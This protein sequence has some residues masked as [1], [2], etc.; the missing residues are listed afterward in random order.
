MSAVLELAREL[1]ARP[2]LTPDDA[3]CQQLIGA[4]LAKLSFKIEHLRFGQVDNLWARHGNSSPLLV[5]AGHTDV[6]PPGPKEQWK[7]DPFTP[8][9]RDGFLYGRGTADM[10]TGLAAMTVA[11]EQFITSQP[12]HRGSLAFLITS[13]EEGPS[14]DGTV[15]VMEELKDRG[16]KID[17]CVLGEPSCLEKFGDT[18]RHGRRGSLTGLLHVYGIQG[19]VAYPERADNPIH[20]VVPAL[21]ELCATKW[22]TSA[23]LHFPPTSFQISNFNSGTGAGNVIPGHADVRFNFRYSTA[24]T[25]VE[26]QQRVHEILD[27]H[28]LRYELEWRPMGEPFLTKPGE[29]SGV[30]QAAVKKVTDLE[31]RLDTGGGT[32]DGRFIA[33]TGAQVVEFGPLNVSIHKIDEC[34]ALADLEPLAEIYRE[35]IQRLLG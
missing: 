11:A 17:W 27:C 28:K 3:G 33:P 24:V 35:I 18:L 12:H 2:S 23:N 6:V 14:V 13:D 19:H 31:P 29:L 26:L 34:A 20:R 10:K 32:S 1:V 30:V 9:I 4:R 15:K 25:A 16:E 7:S 5:F 21:T 8:V 22:D